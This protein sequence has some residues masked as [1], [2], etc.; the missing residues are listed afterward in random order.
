MQPRPNRM[1]GN[2]LD[3]YYP[4]SVHTESSR[5]VIFCYCVQILVEWNVESKLSRQ[6]FVHTTVGSAFRSCGRR[7][8]FPSFVNQLTMALTVPLYHRVPSTLKGILPSSF[9]LF[10]LS[11]SF[12]FFFGL[13][14]LT[15][16]TR[17][18]KSRRLFVSP[19]NSVQVGSLFSNGNFDLSICRNTSRREKKRPSSVNGFMDR[20]GTKKKKKLGD[21]LHRGTW[22]KVFDKRA[23][24]KWVWN[25]KCIRNIALLVL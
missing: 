22:R 1:T 25:W 11:L 14:D 2:G 18:Q 24:V 16:K 23:T 21:L 7:L 13:R 9:S 10:F 6:G 20:T 19:C 3:E 12:I 4:L 15:K 5:K 17:N 8:V